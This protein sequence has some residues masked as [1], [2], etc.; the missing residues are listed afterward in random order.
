MKMRLF[1]GIALD[2]ALTDALKR[3]TASLR[4][5]G[6]G[7]RWSSPES[8]HITLQFLGATDPQCYESLLARLSEIHRPPLAIH[9][10]VPDVFERAG[11]FHIGVLPSQHLTALER[12]VVAATA[13]CGIRP[14]DHPYHPHITLVRSKGHEG[15]RG[16]HALLEH[17]HSPHT[18]PSF[19]AHEFLLYQ[20]L[21]T[22]TGS[23]YEIR[24]RFPLS[25]PPA[26]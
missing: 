3:L 20:S 18:L 7:L 24:A 16:L 10:G 15:R 1:V 21:P 25:S 23:R 13:L 22:P 12:H 19:T 14:E 26:Q 9:L 8:W 17:L 11:V 2:P 6:D 4:R 5:A